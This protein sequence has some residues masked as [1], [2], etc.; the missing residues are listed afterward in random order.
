MPKEQS[1]D[2]SPNISA[3]FGCSY[4]LYLVYFSQELQIIE[5]IELVLYRCCHLVAESSKLISWES[6]RVKGVGHSGISF[7]DSGQ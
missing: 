1:R 6:K 2:Y 7:L 5:Q 4:T 3:Y